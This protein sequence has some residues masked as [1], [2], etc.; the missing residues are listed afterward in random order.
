[1]GQGSVVFHYDYFNE[2]LRGGR[3]SVGWMVVKVGDPARSEDV[4]R[5]VDV[6]FVNSAA[7]TK[8]ATER[9]FI[10]Q[11]TEQIGNMAPSSSRSC[12]RCFSRCY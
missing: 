12:R 7:E 6:L 1:M 5:R 9:A 11:T 10:K 8:T 3:D 4:A 2:S